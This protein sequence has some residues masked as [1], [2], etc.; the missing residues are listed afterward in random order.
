MKITSVFAPVSS[1]GLERERERER[2]RGRDGGFFLRDRERQREEDGESEGWVRPFM[3]KRK[4]PIERVSERL[5]AIS[6]VF[7]PFTPTHPFII[8]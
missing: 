8:N 3:L 5:F 7:Y 4:R 2:E 1:H 6:H